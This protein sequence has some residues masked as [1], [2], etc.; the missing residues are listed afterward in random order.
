MGTKNSA[1]VFM[2]FNSEAHISNCLYFEK[3]STRKLVNISLKFTK[4]LEKKETG[5]FLIVG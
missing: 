5:I 4:Q 3:K 2:L 1:K